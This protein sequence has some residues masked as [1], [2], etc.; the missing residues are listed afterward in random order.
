MPYDEEI[1]ILLQSWVKGDK[2]GD[3]LRL[4]QRQLEYVGAEESSD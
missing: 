3:A 4:E 2:I 1:A